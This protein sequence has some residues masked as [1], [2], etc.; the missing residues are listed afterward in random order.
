MLIQT[1]VHQPQMIGPI[2]THT[3]VWVWGLLAALLS[4]G[5]SQVAARTAGLRRVTV[6]PIAMTVFS[7]WG[8]V[9]AFG[10][11]S[12]FGAVLAVWF[13]AAVAMLAVLAP[14]A[15][16]A[17]TSYDAARRSFHLPGSWVPLALIAGIFLV[18]YGVG[19]ELA[20]Q[21][22]L[23]GDR[24]YALVAGTIYGAFS[25]IFIGRTARLWRM[26]LRPASLPSRAITA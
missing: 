10:N 9:T 2:L 20:M 6:M 15:P 8:T 24:Q 5:L 25:G 26:A 23:A 22:T 17:G 3:P 11:S 13:L 12:Q 4:L 16:A 7:L 19:V 14:M 21:P 1:L 18:K